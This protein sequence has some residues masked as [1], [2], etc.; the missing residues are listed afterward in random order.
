MRLEVRWREVTAAWTVHSP[1]STLGG[2]IEIPGKR[3]WSRA[4]NSCNIT[5]NIVVHSIKS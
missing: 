5:R 3:S 4:H 2:P 1:S